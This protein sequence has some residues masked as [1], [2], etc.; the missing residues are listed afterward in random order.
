MFKH[1]LKCLEPVLNGLKVKRFLLEFLHF[2]LESIRLLVKKI[3]VFFKLLLGGL[4]GF[5]ETTNNII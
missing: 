3:Y 2:F 1:F 4:R 5:L